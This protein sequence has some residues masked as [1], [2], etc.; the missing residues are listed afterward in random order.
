MEQEIKQ[1]KVWNEKD[2]VYDIVK[3]KLYCVICGD[4][5]PR[6]KKWIGLE[7]YRKKTLG[8]VK[9]LNQRR[10]PHGVTCCNKC[11]YEN[12][13]MLLR[14]AANKYYHKNK[15]NSTFRLNKNKINRNYYQRNKEKISK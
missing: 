2:F 12:R 7:L 4:V 3:M 1:V 6:R 10:G 14:K 5:I 15:D 11:Y 8:Q 9:I 13:G